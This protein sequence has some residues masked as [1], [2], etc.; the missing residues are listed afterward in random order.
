MFVKVIEPRAD[1]DAWLYKHCGAIWSQQ[2]TETKLIMLVFDDFRL[3]GPV[4]C[5]FMP[6][7][8]PEYNILGLRKNQFSKQTTHNNANRRISIININLVL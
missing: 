4:I 5:Y 6:I 1:I 3:K 2:Q 7:D 8:A